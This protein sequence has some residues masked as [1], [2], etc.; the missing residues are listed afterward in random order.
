M[1]NRLF[2]QHIG[3]VRARS[4]P[5][6]ETK[7]ALPA[8]AS[9]RTAFPDRS[10]IA[11][12]VKK[13]VGDLESQADIMGIGPQCLALLR[14]G[15]LPRI[16]PASQREGDQPAGLHLLQPGDRRH[17]ELAFP[18][19][20]VEHLPADHAVHPRRPRPVRRPARSAPAGR[21]GC[22]DR[23]APRRRGS[24]GRHRPGSRS[25]RRI[26]LW[27]VAGRGEDRRR[28]SPADRHGPANSCAPSRRP[29]RR[30]GASSAT[31]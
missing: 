24:A 28:P 14:G 11:F 19:R 13:I 9:L 20:A 21:H 5:S 25:P 26:A 6:S 4:T 27:Q 8:P 23:P 31:R 17:V 29:R 3:L 10:R 7:V 22:R 30:D 12:R 18:R 1:P 2:G 16:A 15:A